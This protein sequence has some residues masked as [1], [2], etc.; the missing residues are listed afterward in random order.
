[1]TLSYHEINNIIEITNDKIST[2]V[3]ENRTL[4]NNFILDMYQ[5]TQGFDGHTTIYNENELI[6]FQKNVDL[7]TTFI[8]FEINRKP[9][10]NKIITALEKNAIVNHYEETMSIL[11]EIERYLDTISRDYTIIPS[12]TKNTV[13]SLIKSAG[14]F[15][16]ENQD[17]VAEKMIDYM[18]LV[19]EFDSKKL[20]IT[21]G[22]RSCMSDELSELFMKTVLDHDYKILMIECVS[23]KM[24]S[25]ENRLT[26]DQDLC[27]F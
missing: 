13:S 3:I 27:E 6:D 17:N 11:C 8:P 21:A 22:M 23:D 16:D 19:R 24:L 2:I 4:Y 7:T 10:V 12:Y 18:E 20:F 15:I 25:Y 9:L 1:M 26:I 14:I 5:Q